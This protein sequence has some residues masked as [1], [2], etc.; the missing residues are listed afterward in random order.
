MFTLTFSQAFTP[1]LTP[2]VSV[3]CI[4]PH[5]LPPGPIFTSVKPSL[6]ISVDLLVHI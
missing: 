2:A 3:I 5:V 4:V 6:R 1:Y